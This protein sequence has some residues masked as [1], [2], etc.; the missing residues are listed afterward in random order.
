M[1]DDPHFHQGIYNVCGYDAGIHVGQ[2]IEGL[3][4]SA[5]NEFIPGEEITLA[6]QYN[7]TL[8]YHT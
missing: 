6:S 2:M 5:Y 1:R 7:I 3:T 4:V 8:Q